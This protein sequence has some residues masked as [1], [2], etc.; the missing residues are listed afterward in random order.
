MARSLPFTKMHGL[1]NDFVVI[2]AREE[3][4]DLSPEAIQRLADRRRGVG[5]DQLVAI[6]PSEIADARLLFFNADGSEAGA[7]GNGTRCVSRLLM[8]EGDRD[9]LR[10]ETKGGL[11]RARRRRDGLVTVE[12]GVPRTDWRDIPLAVACDTLEVPLDHAGLPRPTATSMG[13]PHATFFVDD[14]D[15][16]DVER[17]GAELER[18]PIFPERANIGFAMRI[19]PSTIR[20]K[21]FERGA[22]LT[23]ACGTGAC[24]AMVAARRRGLVGEVASLI[25]D[26]GPLEIAWDGKGPV[27][28]TGP[29]AVVF[30]GRIAAELLEGRT[31]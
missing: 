15:A 24:A 16:L 11:L 25:L 7:C 4:L 28:M 5:F 23:P 17:L 31:P 3:T 8:M 27:S 30:E 6:A 2:D 1:G 26:G 21:V 14:L 19:G 20:L 12:M 9:E 22:G 10:L 29:V 13:N 18:H